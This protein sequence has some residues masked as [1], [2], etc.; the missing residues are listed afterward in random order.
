M[1]DITEAVALTGT[2]N[3]GIVKALTGAAAILSDD[4]DDFLVKKAYIT[5]IGD[6]ENG[7][8][9]LCELT[10]ILDIAYNRQPRKMSE[11]DILWR[12]AMMPDVEILQHISWK[13][14][15]FRAYTIP[16][17]GQSYGLVVQDSGKGLMHT[18]AWCVAIGKSRYRVCG[19][20]DVQTHFGRITNDGSNTWHLEKSTIKSD[21]MGML[22]SPGAH[23]RMMG[24]DENARWWDWIFLA[25]FP[26]I[27][28]CMCG[29]L[30]HK[31][32]SLP[33]FAD[34]AFWSGAGLFAIA[35]TGRALI[36]VKRLFK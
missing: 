31:F 24:K 3:S 36:S 14:R 34:I 29:W 11:V 19:G 5:V 10:G 22:D 12:S 23:L 35:V 17:P 13:R 1:A 27:L 7:G 20:F 8:N 33:S 25:L 9:P 16:K 32:M 21:P 4:A 30:A 15:L 28:L 18:V 2:G 26:T 6:E